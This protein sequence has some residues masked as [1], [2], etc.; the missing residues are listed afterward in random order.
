MSPICECSFD[1]ESLKHFSLYFPRYAAQRDF[2]LTSAANILGE[3]RSSSRVARKL[4]FLLYGVEFVNYDV[5]CALFHEVQS[6]IINTNRF[7]EAIV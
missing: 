4:N 7:S 6:F 5:N 2:L 3:T 1:S